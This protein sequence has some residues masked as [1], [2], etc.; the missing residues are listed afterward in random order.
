MPKF[1]QTRSSLFC[2]FS[3]PLVNGNRWM[4]AVPVGYAK[5][6]LA[7]TRSRSSDHDCNVRHT[8]AILFR[9]IG[10]NSTAPTFWKFLARASSASYF[11]RTTKR[12]R[13]YSATALDEILLRRF[14]RR[15]RESAN[16][17]VPYR[18]GTTWRR[19]VQRVGIPSI[20]I[21]P[22]LPTF[23][24]STADGTNHLILQ[25]VPLPPDIESAQNFQP[26]L[27]RNLWRHHVSQTKSEVSS[28]RPSP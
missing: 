24:N 12:R 8:T 2:G 7:D 28:N 18:R 14:V 22:N 19:T 26:L 4:T 17:P 11:R 23:E 27:R 16:Q 21:D 13:R 5:E 9:L 25:R 15:W 10:Q 6:L 1:L 20:A 3:I